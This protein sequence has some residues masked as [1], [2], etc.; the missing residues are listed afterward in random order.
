MAFT[1]TVNPNTDVWPPLP[2]LDDKINEWIEKVDYITSSRIQ[3]GF[4]VPV[5]GVTYH[6]SFRLSDQTN[7]L[8]MMTKATSE[9]MTTFGTQLKAAQA[10]LAGTA[11]SPAVAATPEEEAAN[12]AGT[13]DTDSAESTPENNE[14]SETVTSPVEGEQGVTTDP[15]EDGSDTPE[16]PVADPVFCTWQGHKDGEAHTLPFT[17]MEFIAFA[18]DIGN[19]KQALLAEGWTTKDQLR[20]VKTEQELV[21]LAEYLQIDLKYRDAHDAL[22]ALGADI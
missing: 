15:P 2:T 7:F 19:R 21:D 5:K 22:K 18:M 8:M 1:L 6:F 13:E 12:A 17:L 14:D 4:D 9:V 20:A 11:A 16:V 10:A 3:Q